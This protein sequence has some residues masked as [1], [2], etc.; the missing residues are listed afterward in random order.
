MGMLC[1]LMG[2]VAAV[3]A[4]QILRM[5]VDD[6]T[7]SITMGKLLFYAGLI[8]GISMVEGFFR[9]L[10]RRLLIGVSRYVE[11]DLRSDFFSHLQRMSSSFYQRW[12]TGDLMSRASND[13]AAVRMVL[14]PGIMYP[15]ET[16]VITI[17]ALTF[18]LFISVELTLVSLAVMPIVSISVKKFGAVIHKRFESIQA[19]MSDISALVQENLSGMRVVKAYTQETHQQHKFEKDNR[20]YLRRNIGLVKVWGAFFPLLGVFIGLGSALVLWWGGHMVMRDEITLGEL[21]AF[22]AYLGM[23]TWPMIA[24]GWVVNIYQRGAAS[25][26]RLAAIWNES[27]DLT[28]AHD[29]RRDVEIVGRIELRGVNFRYNGVPVLRDISLVIEPGQTVAL[30]GRTGSGKTTLV[31]LIPRLYDTTDGVVLVDGVDVRKLPLANLRR[32]VGF[33][34]QESFLF[35][36]TV[37]QNIA[38]GR[39]SAGVEEIARAADVAGLAGDIADFPSGYET[40]VGERGITLSGG[41]RQ[42]A[43]IARALLTDPPILVLDDALSSV[44]T[45]TEERILSR[46]RGVMRQRTTLIVSHRISTIKEADLIVVLDEGSIVEQGTHEELIAHEGIYAGLYQKQLLE[47][48]LERI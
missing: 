5:T 32:A 2:K 22:F 43:T 26:K 44:D 20:E 12:R 1:L 27:P 8:V 28:D 38:F 42:R 14:G 33:V 18:M 24:F 10:M 31:S 23:L 39:P 3:L 16:A 35:S 41:Q 34:P 37:G 15:A 17:A 4:P 21:V 6:L 7:V 47:E 30:V 46:L 19:K 36:E 29:A 13:I 25:M 48:E 11:Y 9:F 45:E 40:M